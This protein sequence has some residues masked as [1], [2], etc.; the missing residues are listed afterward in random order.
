MGPVDGAE[1]VPPYNIHI[2][3][4]LT[5]ALEVNI[6]FTFAAPSFAVVVVVVLLLL[7]VVVVVVIVVIVVIVVVAAAVVVVVVARTPL[8]PKRCKSQRTSALPNDG[9]TPQLKSR[10]CLAM[11][12]ILRWR[13]APTQVKE[14]FGNVRY[15][16]L[17]TWHK[18]G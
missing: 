14:V 3:H 1:A 17:G 15:P 13:N 11:A 6:C 18:N 8:E 10:R 5:C 2:H 16:T 9:E 7:L 4:Q 12:D